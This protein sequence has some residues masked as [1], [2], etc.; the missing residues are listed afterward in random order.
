MRY[1]ATAIS[2]LA[3]A[4]CSSGG[5][6]DPVY[7]AVGGA[8]L[9]ATGIR[10]EGGGEGGGGGQPRGQRLTRAS[11]EASGLAMIRIRVGEEEG[12]NIMLAS[13]KNGPYLTHV[14]KFQQSV[15]L[16]GGWVTGTRGIGHDLMSAT[17]S[18]NDPVKGQ[19]PPGQWEAQ[20]IEREY[21]FPGVGP[22]GRRVRVDCSFE[23]MDQGEITIVER[24]YSTVRFIET[25]EGEEITFQNTYFVDGRGSV[26]RS[27]QWIGWRL[28]PLDVDILEPYTGS[29]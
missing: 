26:W 3:L 2:L 4:A 7:S 20:K 10:G 8:L 23:A 14:S 25:C 1:L 19:M 9:E 22:A 5:R 13:A 11:I 17:S 16:N 29:R 12:F 27:R 18:K 24:S 21:E 15:T 6:V 28:P